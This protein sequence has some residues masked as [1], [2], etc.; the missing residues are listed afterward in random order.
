MLVG[1]VEVGGVDVGGVLVGG[2]L[3]GG[4]LVGGI[5]VGIGQAAAARWLDPFLEGG[6]SLIFPFALML[7]L[8]MLRP[9][10]LFGWKRV[11]RI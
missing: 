8:L 11:E 6:A 1:G 10:G 3:V 2:V 5:I 4:V 9:H 7:V